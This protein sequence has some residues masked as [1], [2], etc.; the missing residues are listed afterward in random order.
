MKMSEIRNMDIAELKER[1]ADYKKKY[2]S[3]KLSHAVTP[4]ENPME[5]RKMR[6]TIARLMTELNQRGN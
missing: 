6:K 3:L 5:I 2:D 4:L 1:L